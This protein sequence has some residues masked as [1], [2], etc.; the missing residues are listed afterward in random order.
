MI[1]ILYGSTE[2]QFNTNG[3]GRLSDA[4]SCQVEENLNGLY[5]LTMVYPIT[6]QHY[7]EIEENRIILAEPFEGGDWQPFIIYRISRPLNGI[8]T[9]NAEH[10]SYLLNKIIVMPYTAGSCTAALASL[11]DHTAN[12]CPFTFWTDKSVTGQF[13][14]A[15][16]RPARGLL[17]GEEGS[18]LDVY[19]KGEYEFNRYNV[20]LYVN[21]GVDRGVT[22]RY[23]K[24]LTNLVRDKDISDC[25][26][27]IVP[28]WQSEDMLVTL[29][30]EVVWSDYREAFPNEIVRA[31]DFSSEWED[32]P[33]EDQLRARATRYVTTNEGWKIADNISISFVALWQ[34]TE[35]AGIAGIERV[36]M[37][38]TVHVVY[39]ALGVETSA[40]VI[41]TVYDVLM[42]RYISIE[43]GTKRNSLGT[44]IADNVAPKIV[45][46]T[47]S[48]MDDALKHATDLLT[49]ANGG[50]V[51]IGTNADG[52]PNEIFVMD[53]EDQ[54]TAQQVLRINKNGIG[55]SSNGVDGP[56]DTAWTLDGHFV[57][58]YIASGVLDANL[59]RA[60]TIRDRYGQNW[61]NLDT[62]EMHISAE[63]YIDTSDFVTQAQFTA[64]ADQIAT[65]VVEQVGSGIFF[66]VLPT[67][68]GQ[69]VTL[70]AHVYLNRTDATLS[71]SPQFFHWYKKTESGRFYLG[72]GYE[73]TVIKSEYGYGGEVEAT[74]LTLVD[75]YPVTNQ[76]KWVF[77]MFG[78]YH[79]LVNSQGSL[80]LAQG[81]PVV[82]SESQDSGNVYP[83]FGYDNDSLEV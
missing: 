5:E 72:Y 57:A 81:Y 26:T 41:Q 19:G 17:G 27:G 60:G 59:V 43:L 45:Q 49:G 31:V 11:P 51:V 8:V 83:V 36:R 9:I 39:D 23:G 61:W 62:G 40:E 22:L 47:T 25:Y 63:S 2:T 29:P 20:R 66:N 54:S 80:R 37:G 68:N 56:F 50:Y 58:D 30:E 77:T 34:T 71:F 48:Y 79:Q 75:R 1:P 4:I 42:E 18:I 21:R 7:A 69:T 14:V 12:N 53:T 73:M 44:V 15:Y 52:E 28:Y 6:G 16:P 70:R 67:D 38:D 64:A 10:I 76:G 65:E 74:F 24:N 33:D 78:D 35:Y 13:K 55:F 3:I 46:E 82:W 32:A